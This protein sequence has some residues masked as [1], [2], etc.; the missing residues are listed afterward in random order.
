MKTDKREYKC[1]D[2]EG[3]KK[4]SSG[5]QKSVSGLQQTDEMVNKKTKKAQNKGAAGQ[6][7]VLEE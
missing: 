6:K 2:M 4:G 7:G 1:E 3:T 5:R